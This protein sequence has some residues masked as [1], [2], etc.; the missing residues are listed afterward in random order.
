MYSTLSGSRPWSRRNIHPK[1]LTKN[2][3]TLCQVVKFN[4][5]LFRYKDNLAPGDSKCVFGFVIISKRSF[6]FKHDSIGGVKCEVLCSI[7]I[8]C[9]EKPLKDFW[10]FKE[11]NCDDFCPIMLKYFDIEQYFKQ[12]LKTSALTKV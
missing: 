6:K 2:I 9:G 4:L 11:Q 7:C 3:S 12:K 5:A 10:T 1:F 8:F